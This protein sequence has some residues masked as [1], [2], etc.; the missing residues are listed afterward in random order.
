MIVKICDIGSCR[1]ITNEATEW[2]T[3]VGTV[4]FLAP[5]LIRNYMNTG[6]CNNPFKSDVF[7]LGLCLLYLVTFKKFKSNERLKVEERIYSEI[8]SEWV[9]E[10]K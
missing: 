7:S 5:E 8:I 4:P 1:V 10:G 3:L 2:A 9:K 6:H